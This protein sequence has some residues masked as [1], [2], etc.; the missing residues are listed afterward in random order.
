MYYIAYGSNLNMEQMQRRCPTAVAIGKGTLPG[1]ELNFR[2]SKSGNYLTID[3]NEA[4][5]VPVGIWKI[6]QSDL[7]SL[8]LYEGYPTFYTRELIEVD[9]RGLKSRRRHKVMAYVYIMNSGRRIGQPSLHYMST[10]LGGYK[11]FDFPIDP[12]REA[13]DRSILNSNQI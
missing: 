6:K 11:D 13:Y 10:C 5:S 1:Y 12:L 2:G 7:E 9:Y 4:G 8:D 3:R